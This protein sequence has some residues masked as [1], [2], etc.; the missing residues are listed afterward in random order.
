MNLYPIITINEYL[1]LLFC[2]QSDTNCM[3]ND[4][5]SI[6]LSLQILTEQ[7]KSKTYLMG[8]LKKI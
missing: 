6:T 4:T 5:S 2:T 8:N 3:V 7:K 1:I